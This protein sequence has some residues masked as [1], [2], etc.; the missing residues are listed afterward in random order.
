MIALTCAQPPAT[1]AQEQPEC[2]EGFALTP[3]LC[4]S[5]EVTVDGFANLRGGVRTGVAGI[6]QVW[7]D[8]DVDLG[9][10]AGLEGWTGRASLIGILGRQPTPTL[11][12]GLAPSSNIEAVSTVRLF[13][14]WLD[15]SFG[16]HGSLRFGQLSA[17]M[18]FATIES[19]RTLV[20]GTFGWPVALGSTLPGGGPG[21]PLATPGVRVAL[22]DPKDETGVRLAIYSG[23][24]G[25]RHGID[26][27]PQ[28]HNRY[29]VTFSTSGGIFYLGEAVTGAARP[30]ETAPRP[31]VLKLGGWYHNGGF[32]SQRYASDGRP[33]A[34]PASNGVPRRYGNNYGGYLVG[35]AVLWRDESESVL[36]FTRAFAQ[37][38]DR[39]EVALQID[40]G[41]AWNGPFGRSSDT[42]ALA[43]SWARVGKAGRGYDRDLL[44]FGTATPVRSHETLLE[45]NYDFAVEPD[46]LYVRPLMQVLF[47][48]AAGAADERRSATTSLPDAVLVGLRA[49]ARF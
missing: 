35:E 2:A 18:E 32:D 20:S 48:P 7:S 17:D 13:E 33:L 3:G 21:Y 27:N 30:S 31:W 34:D 4:L 25:G 38:G 29:G 49:V 16:P 8:L 44:T 26:T 14:F 47:N 1:R 12:G 39:N 41:V 45:V 40:G 6:G 5:T 9:T 10:L 15:R 23:N 36:A 43:V 11:T 28:D 46:R 22:G 37:P 42:A 24:P 19:A